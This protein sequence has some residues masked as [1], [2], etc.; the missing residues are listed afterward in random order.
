MGAVSTLNG[1]DIA[2]LS[3]L[4][5]SAVFG[6]FRGLVREILSLMAWI[7]AAWLALRYH[8]WLADR[9]APVIGQEGIRQAAGFLLLFIAA[10]ISAS[11][12]NRLL[13]MLVHA[14]RLGGIDRL[15]G[16]IFG[17]L[18]G[19]M[20]GLV[21][22]ALI[23]MTP[24]GDST[25]WADSVVVETYRQLADWLGRHVEADRGAAQDFLSRWRD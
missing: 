13:S 10:I 1:L 21:F 12:L 2:L 7:V 18:R 23:D 14:S 19:V 11:L 9:L 6:A 22:V 16:F 15:L 20:I 4:G 3:V 8:A 25:A 5:L 17:A 24:L